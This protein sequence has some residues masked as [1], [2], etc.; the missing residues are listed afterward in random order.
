[1]KYWLF[2][3]FMLV[4]GGA[5]EESKTLEDMLKDS[6]GAAERVTDIMGKTGDILSNYADGKL[7]DTVK[8][9]PIK[10]GR[11][12]GQMFE[13]NGRK[14]GKKLFKKTKAL[15]VIKKLGDSL[16]AV[17][18]F[19][20]P[21]FIVGEIIWGDGADHDHQEVM[22]K[23][24]DLEVKMERIS[25]EIS[26]Q[27]LVL[28]EIIRSA[29]FRD[30]YVALKSIGDKFRSLTR[31]DDQG[32][33]NHL[34]VKYSD[35]AENL[36]K[37][38]A[39]IKDYFTTIQKLNYG[40][41]VELHKIRAWLTGMMI[42][43]LFGTALG[44]EFHLKQ[45]G[46]T[47]ENGKFN[48]EK[49]CLMTVERQTI[50]RINNKMVDILEKCENKDHFGH[51]LRKFIEELPSV[52]GLPKAQIH[53]RDMIANFINK[54]FPKWNYL[55][56]VFEEKPASWNER[57]MFGEQL[58]KFGLKGQSYVVYFGLEK[59]KCRSTEGGR[60]QALMSSVCPVEKSGDS[61]W[62]RG[63]KK[64]K[65][66]CTKETAR[67]IMTG[68]NKTHWYSGCLVFRG[69]LRGSTSKGFAF[70]RKGFE[71][72]VEQTNC[73]TKETKPRW[74]YQSTYDEYVMNTFV[75][76]CAGHEY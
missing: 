40:S 53:N 71:E 43:A 9:E 7:Q 34:K 44:C 32:A 13:M 59:R 30:S 20:A 26:Q 16:A 41:C 36:Y 23:L 58:L 39:N 49:D 18:T 73:F 61:K 56:I 65:C 66:K 28:T 62:T 15:K 29:A 17:C 54:R 63:P 60:A 27:T 22:S 4:H 55:V 76:I 46:K 3:S 67:D 6:Q 64:G 12:I 1:M 75:T 33:K 52:K 31:Y 57:A 74:H 24:Q 68:L 51:W 19:A 14:G 47:L 45:Q 42:N 72:C 10:H 37:L 35:T 25:D 69:K 11:E 8:I 70:R 5:S 21:L 2:L 50:I 38:E 48:P